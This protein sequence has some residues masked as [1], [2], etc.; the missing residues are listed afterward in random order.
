M[1]YQMA[2]LIYNGVIKYTSGTRTWNWQKGNYIT[3]K[4]NCQQIHGHVRSRRNNSDYNR[5]RPVELTPL[6]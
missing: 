1:D 6:I 3:T 4:Y 5:H 2:T